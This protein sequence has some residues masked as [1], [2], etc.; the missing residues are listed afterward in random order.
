MFRYKYFCKAG[1]GF[2]FPTEFVTGPT[3][4]AS[5]T[6]IRVVSSSPSASRCLLSLQRSCLNA[7]T[8]RWRSPLDSLYLW[9]I[10]PLCLLIYWLLHLLWRTCPLVPVGLAIV[11]SPSCERHDGNI[12]TFQCIWTPSSSPPFPRVTNTFHLEGVS[13]WKVMDG[14][15]PVMS[16]FR[17]TRMTFQWSCI[18]IEYLF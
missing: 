12:Y 1:D 3:F 13:E 10:F 18:A 11:C 14:M 9:I 2:N 4:S 16:F 5:S 15:V 6:A 8:T 17:R 7:F